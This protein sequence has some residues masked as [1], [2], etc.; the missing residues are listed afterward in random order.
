MAEAAGGA[1]GLLV[2]IDDLNT[3]LD[4]LASSPPTDA[5]LARGPGHG[6]RL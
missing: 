4:G 1:H 2:I 5:N 6:L 3:G